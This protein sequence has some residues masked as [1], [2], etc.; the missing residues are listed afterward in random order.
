MDLDIVD[1]SRTMAYHFPMY[2]PVAGV[3]IN[4]RGRQPQGIVEPGADFE[5]VRG[6][7]V[8]ALRDARDPE[9]DR[10]FVTE[11]YKSEEVY[12][13]PY[14]GIAPDIVY[15]TGSEHYA[16][17]GLPDAWVKPA[18]L[19][20]MTEYF[21]VHTME[22]VLVV[23]GPTV[24]AGVAVTNANIGDIAPTLLYAL[25]EPVPR[26]MDGRVLTEVFEP[27]HLD[28]QPP[29]YAELALQREVV[30]GHTAREE[31]EMRAKLRGLGYIS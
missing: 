22:G 13:G 8:A 6:E 28:A 7:V 25:G 27:E 18:P 15:R 29:R 14:L 11:V 1:W 23:A 26:H 3:E 31:E 4:V 5:R 2:H 20:E 21:G 19:M 12:E 9:T 10:P 17:A 30:A 24:R 16:E